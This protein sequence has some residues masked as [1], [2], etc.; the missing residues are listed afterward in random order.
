MHME[1]VL[2]KASKVAKV[3]GKIA[4]LEELAMD[5]KLRLM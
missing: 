1:I 5:H 3:G 2:D 4:W